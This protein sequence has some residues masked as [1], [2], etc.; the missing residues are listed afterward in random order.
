M[1]LSDL[2]EGFPTG[3]IRRSVKDTLPMIGVIPE[4]D[5]G[6]LYLNYRFGTTLASALAVANG[7]HPYNKQI[8]WHTMQTVAPYTQQ[9]L[10]IVKLACAQSGFTLDM[11]HDDA[12]H[13]PDWVNTKSPVAHLPMLESRR[14]LEA[15]GKQ[16]LSTDIQDTLP[17]VIV[18][19]E[20]NSGNNYPQ[21][22]FMTVMA[23]IRAIKDGDVPYRKLQPWSNSLAVVGYTPEDIETIRMAAAE[24]GFAIDEINSS[25]SHEPDWVNTVSPVMKFKMLEAAG[26][27]ML[28][29]PKSPLIHNLSSAD[30][31]AQSY[32]DTPTRGKPQILVVYPGRFQ[33]LHRGH[34]AV[35]DDLVK[36]FGPNVYIA[37][38]NKTDPDKSPFDFAD[39]QSMARAAGVP[40]DKVVQVKN[41]YNP[42][43][44]TG[45]FEPSNTVLLMAV[46]AKDMDTDPRF[47]LPDQGLAK[48]K[49]GSPAYLQKWPELHRAKTMDQHG[50]IVAA[51][52]KEFEVLGEPATSAT[53]IRAQYRDSDPSQ[54]DQIITDLYGKTNKDLRR[55]FDAKLAAMSED[56]KA[57]LQN[58]LDP[59]GDTNGPGKTGDQWVE[60]SS[61]AR[62]TPKLTKISKHISEKAGTKS[63]KRTNEAASRINDDWFR[64]GSFKTWKNPTPVK[65]EI[66]DTAG[67]VDTLEGP[68]RHDAGHYIMTGPKG[69]RYPI[70]SDKFKT[71]YDDNGNGTATPK[72]VEKL[73]KVAD[74]DG[75]LH[76]SWGDLAY[77]TGN[78]YIVRH[79]PGD[80]GAV[81]AD[82][83]AKT[84]H[85]P[86][87]L[88]ES[89]GVSE[90][91]LLDAMRKFLIIAKEEI[92]LEALPK[93]NWSWDDKVAPDSPS[94][95]RFTN[96]DKSIKI[97]MRNRHPIDIM[98]TLA[99]ELVHYK[100]DVEHRIGPDSG[101]TGS[102]IENEAN[103]LAGQIMRRF[104]H[105]N[106]QL[107]ALSAVTP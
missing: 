71:L 74:H 93:I 70:T 43:E 26:D 8:P 101:E 6:N 31:D 64:N 99:H 14:L 61:H 30:D 29:V 102:P 67:T 27:G 105:E 81:K 87:Q 84:Y 4:I 106:P 55:L 56:Q 48:K 80:Y 57:Y 41:P 28:H 1:K 9:E 18:I 73:A 76:T 51:P 89:A 85:M 19:P 77:T 53:E 60:S 92:G 75:V 44:I 38:S 50:Y 3:K 15:F 91:D 42:A 37:T 11:L 88:S 25:I 90:N 32:Q 12:S 95:G 78:D 52:T 22:R 23:S 107:F 63:A 34:K 40:S 69:E 96:T 54:R 82:I 13:E 35:Y 5:N 86:T 94:F 49:D 62:N 7:E 2:F 39:K 103:A 36:Q 47:K 46:G 79:G 24:A 58:P 16:K 17:P 66:A 100:Q 45:L 104:D 98:R 21:Y 65:Y 59:E 83:F 10:D 68:M 20:L 97:I 33:P 72:R